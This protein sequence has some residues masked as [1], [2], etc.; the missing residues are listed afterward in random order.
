VTRFIVP[1]IGTTVGATLAY[2]YYWF[3]GCDSG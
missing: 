2:A 3:W 1:A